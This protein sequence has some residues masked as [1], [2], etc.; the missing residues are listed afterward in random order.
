M[1]AVNI[2]CWQNIAIQQFKQALFFF[3]QGCSIFWE[4]VCGAGWCTVFCSGLVFVTRK[5]V[6]YWQCSLS[7]GASREDEQVILAKHPCLSF[8]TTVS[9]SP[10][11]SSSCS[12]NFIYLVRRTT[13][14]FLVVST[15]LPLYCRWWWW[16]FSFFYFYLQAFALFSLSQS[17]FLLTRNSS[18]S[19]FL[20]CFDIPPL[21]T[22]WHQSA[23]SLTLTASCCLS[24]L[25][26]RRRSH[27]FSISFF[28]TTLL[29]TF[30]SLACFLF[31]SVLLPG[32]L[33]QKNFRLWL[34][35]LKFFSSANYEVKSAIS[36]SRTRAHTQIQTQFSLYAADKVLGLA[37]ETQQS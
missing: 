32:N 37:L 28:T 14:K 6:H 18:V 23:T 27:F 4:L 13:L 16:C 15:V 20:F 12:D 19:S 11:R 8:L 2:W 3:T 24:K 5:C 1:E 26:R 10:G 9:S 22:F 29:Y 25:S 21:G 17:F 30:A 36:Q 33:V 7:Q 31:C 34:H 35:F